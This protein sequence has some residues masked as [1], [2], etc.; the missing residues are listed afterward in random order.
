VGQVNAPFDPEFRGSPPPAGFLFR[1]AE[2]KD[3]GAVSRLMAERNPDQPHA[4]HVTKTERE[5][6]RNSNDPRYR[7]FVADLQGSCVGLC[8]YFHSDGLSAE[9][10]VFPAP[11]GWYGMGILVDQ[12]FRRQGIARFLFEGR[13]KSL[14]AQGA[15]ELYSMTAA[16]N[17]ASQRMHEAFG[18]REIARAPG[19][20][21]IPFECGSGQLYHRTL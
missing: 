15:A 9:K 16:D 20:L 21:H 3:V 2:S 11:S 5:I 19:F 8:R 1:L 13:L 12:K 6:V 7:L 4:E 17:F 18:F 10:I 14:R